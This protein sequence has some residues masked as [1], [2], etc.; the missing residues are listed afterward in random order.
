ME[1]LLSLGAVRAIGVS[2]FDYGLLHHLVGGDGHEHKGIARAPVL[3][4]QNRADPLSLEDESVL[5]LCRQHN[6]N[7]Q[8]F[9]VLG[10]QWTVGPWSAYWKAEAHPILGHPQVVAIA[11]RLSRKTAKGE[12][13]APVTSAQVILRWALQKGWTVVP[14]TA[15]AHR[16]DSNRQLFHFELNDLDMGIIDNLKAPPR[17]N[18]QEL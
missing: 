2:N 14:K 17:P 4:I 9:I 11:D 5:R 3:L 6:I 18:A 16:L 13:G 10:R 12:S 1:R 15:K 7:Y 8:S